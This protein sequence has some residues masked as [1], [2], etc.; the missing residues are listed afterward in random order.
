[1]PDIRNYPRNLGAGWAFGLAGYAL[2]FGGFFIFI[3][4]YGNDSGLLMLAGIGVL[5]GG[6]LMRNRGMKHRYKRA[7]EVLAEDDRDPVLY[8]RS[9]DMEQQDNTFLRFLK[10]IFAGRALA[11]GESAWGP[12]EQE[13]LAGYMN[14][15]GPYIAIGRPGESL[16]ERGPAWLYI[17]DDD[18]QSVVSDYLRRARMVVV[19]IGKSEGLMWEVDQIRA[20][21]NPFRVLF[22]LP[23]SKGEYRQFC[24]WADEVFARAMP[25]K[26][27]RSRLVMFSK[28]WEPV[29]VPVRD[30]LVDTLAP[31]FKQNRVRL[32]KAWDTR[33]RA[34]DLD[35]P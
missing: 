26:L 18:W 29:E 19:R 35:A 21:C 16:P 11:G 10:D 15:A 27:P 7:E 2:M 3:I 17:T 25:P 13:Q 30:K 8:L 14:M 4:G 5:V 9:F 32:P 24:A 34:E 12:M 6:G 28:R 31:F 23:Q 1:M 33:G 22:I 20:L